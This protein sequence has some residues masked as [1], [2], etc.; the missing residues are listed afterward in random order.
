VLGE[1]ADRIPEALETLVMSCLEKPPEARPATAREVQA[2]L[3]KALES[4]HSGIR[5]RELQRPERA[6]S[7]DDFGAATCI[8]AVDASAPSQVLLPVALDQAPEHPEEAKIW[9]WDQA[10]RLSKALARHQESLRVGSPEVAAHFLALAAIDEAITNLEI[11]VTVDEARRSEVEVEGREIDA[12][13]RHAVVDL[14]LQR[15]NLLDDPAADPLR[16]K[17][18]TYQ[19]T[20]IERRRFEQIE[21]FEEELEGLVQKLE[22][23]KI[24]LDVL[25][26]EQGN[27][28][29]QL[30]RQ[31]VASKPQSCSEQVAA[32]FVQMETLVVL[33]G[34]LG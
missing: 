20:E 30:I 7:A 8:G 19:I 29:S 3:V 25:L 32:A 5:R 2:V 1:A 23:A 12:Q 27:G 14:S 13:L 4:R 17:D 28:E 11:E 6:R 26:A 34:M 31:L 21:R 16:V 18:L 24:R 9:Y 15:T 10:V 22:A 33:S